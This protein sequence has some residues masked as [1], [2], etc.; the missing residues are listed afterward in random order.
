METIQPFGL[1]QLKAQHQQAAVFYGLAKVG[2]EQSQAA[3]DANIAAQA[4]SIQQ[5]EYLAMAAKYLQML[6]EKVSV[7]NIRKLEDLVNSALIQTIPD[8]NFQFAINSAIRRGTT[9]YT[10]SITKDGVEGNINSFGGGA[11]AI[12]AFML[13]V[14][15]QLISRRYPLLVLDES[16]NFIS[17]EYQPTTSLFLKEMAKQFN[18]TII[19]VSHQPAFSEE[20]DC[21]YRLAMNHSSNESMVRTIKALPTEKELM[22]TM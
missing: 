13:K 2:L 11:F 22:G 20:A 17:A 8:Q 15:S 18:C 3:Y 6:I 4:N 9:S 7:S 10:W 12:V 1:S 14:I 19:L 21:H 16:L 5:A